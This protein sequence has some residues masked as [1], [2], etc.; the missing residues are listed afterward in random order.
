MTDISRLEMTVPDDE[1]VTV[2][3]P[4]VQP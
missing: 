4:E 2:Y 1:L 3:V